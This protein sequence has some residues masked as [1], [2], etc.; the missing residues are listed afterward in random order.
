MS[1][2][3]PKVSTRRTWRESSKTVSSIRRMTYFTESY[4]TRRGPVV[5]KERASDVIKRAQCVK[6]TARGVEERAQSAEER[7]TGV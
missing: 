1:R 4:F 3:G 7:A 6:K 5:V 2:R